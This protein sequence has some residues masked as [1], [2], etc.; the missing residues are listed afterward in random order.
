M[1]RTVEPGWFDIMVGPSSVNHQKVR[2]EVL[3]K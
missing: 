3:A 2:L 1:Y